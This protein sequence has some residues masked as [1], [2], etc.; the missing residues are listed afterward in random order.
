ML[1]VI[2]ILTMTFIF[3]FILFFLAYIFYGVLGFISIKSNLVIGLL[4]ALGTAFIGYILQKLLTNKRIVKLVKKINSLNKKK[5]L[6]WVSIILPCIWVIS[7][8]DLSFL[9]SEV[10]IYQTFCEGNRCFSSHNISF[11]PIISAQKVFYKSGPGPLSGSFNT[12]HRE[13]NNCSVISNSSWECDYIDGSITMK[14]NEFVSNK[15]EVIQGYYFDKITMKWRPF[16]EEVA[17]WNW[18][19][20]D[21]VK[22]NLLSKPFWLHTLCKTEGLRYVECVLRNGLLNKEYY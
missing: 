9:K 1:K 14:N 17:T 20:P 4:S 15:P 6:L 13:L 18:K 11:K 21:N 7:Y 2:F 5:I 22:M 8:I 12:S 10:S 3:C 16:D 19:F